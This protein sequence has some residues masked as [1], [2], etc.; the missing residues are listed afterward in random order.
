MVLVSGGA[1]FIGPLG[2]QTRRLYEVLFRDSI[3]IPVG[4]CFRGGIPAAFL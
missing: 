3:G 2:D 4:E 1:G